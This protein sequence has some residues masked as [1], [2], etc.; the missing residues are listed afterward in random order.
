MYPFWGRQ[1]CTQCHTVDSWQPHRHC[2]SAFHLASAA[3]SSDGSTWC[4][5]YTGR[6]SPTLPPGPPALWQSIPSSAYRWN[7]QMELFYQRQADKHSCCQPLSKKM[8]NLKY[9][10]NN[11]IFHNHINKSDHFQYKIVL[12][13]E[14]CFLL[15]LILLLLLIIII[16][17]ILYMLF[18]IWLIKTS[19]LNIPSNILTSLQCC[20]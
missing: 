7:V 20:Y 14:D 15:L 1:C 10:N 12:C 13:I 11:N 5:L 16:I 18:V 3:G 4:S 6:G 8:E 19:R 2:P 17:M 9:M